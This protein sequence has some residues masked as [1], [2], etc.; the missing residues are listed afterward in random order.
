MHGPDPLAVDPR[1]KPVAAHHAHHAVE[2]E[3]MGSKSAPRSRTPNFNATLSSLSL[4]QLLCSELKL[5][6]R[7]L[8]RHRDK[9]GVGKDI[10]W[11]G[12][13]FAVVQGHVYSFMLW[14]ASASDLP[15]SYDRLSSPGVELVG[16]VPLGGSCPTLTLTL[17]LSPTLN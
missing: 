9:T 10:R 12:V 11:P 1:T 16:Q 17:P 6:L 5:K 8:L 14:Y 7:E 2:A 15:L 3:R 4:G 13:C